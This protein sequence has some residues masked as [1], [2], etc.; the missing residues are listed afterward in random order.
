MW[1]VESNHVAAGMGATTDTGHNDLNRGLRTVEKVVWAVDFQKLDVG[2][3]SKE[4]P[5]TVEIGTIVH[6]RGND[7]SELTAWPKELESALEEE[8]EDVDAT[9]NDLSELGANRGRGAELE[10]RRI[11]DDE[12]ERGSGPRI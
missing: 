3:A 9:G 12:I 4:I 10:V 5:Q 11:A 6:R 2:I 1:F 7:I 8:G